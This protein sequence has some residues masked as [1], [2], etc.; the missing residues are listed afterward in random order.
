MILTLS[1]ELPFAS[2]LSFRVLRSFLDSFFVVINSSHA[3][4]A[5]CRT[6]EGIIDNNKLPYL[7]S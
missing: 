5:D 7:Y 1:G 3:F 4:S 6:P 2:E